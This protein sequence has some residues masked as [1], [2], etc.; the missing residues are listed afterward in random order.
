MSDLG[1]VDGRS[2]ISLRELLGYSP[3]APH[4]YFR[5]LDSMH[6]PVH[7]VNSDRVVNGSVN[8]DD[9]VWGIVSTHS[10]YNTNVR[11]V[12]VWTVFWVALKTLQANWIELDVVVEYPQLVGV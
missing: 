7:N 8:E 6:P 5:F 10:R 2:K 3:V 1:K 11:A 12:K 9:V 4:S